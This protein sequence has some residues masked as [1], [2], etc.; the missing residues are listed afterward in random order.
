MRACILYIISVDA[1]FVWKKLTLLSLLRCEKISRAQKGVAG[2]FLL[3]VWIKK[4]STQTK[5]KRKKEA[6]LLSKFIFFS[7]KHA[8]VCI[9]R[10][11]LL[12][13]KK[14]ELKKRKKRTE[15]R[16]NRNASS[17]EEQRSG[18]FYRGD[19]VF[20]FVRAKEKFRLREGKKKIFQAGTEGAFFVTHFLYIRKKAWPLPF[21]FLDREREG[22]RERESQEDRDRYKAKM[23]KKEVRFLAVFCSRGRRTKSDVSH[24]FFLLTSSFVCLFVPRGGSF[25]FFSLSLS[26]SLMNAFIE[27]KRERESESETTFFSSS[28]ERALFLHRSPLCLSANSAPKLTGGYTP[29][30]FGLVLSSH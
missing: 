21:S 6:N 22:E 15:S 26:L 9:Y 4:T 27:R 13:F 16:S 5:K 12:G 3:A 18:S 17:V 11:R 20:T 10:S 1:V 14:R 28:S 29:I 7:L 2:A 8:S 23:G 24:F 19:G 25:Y 30:R